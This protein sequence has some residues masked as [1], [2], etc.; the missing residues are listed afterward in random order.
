MTVLEGWDNFYV[1]VGSSAGA[2]IGLQFVV[3]T[4]IAGAPLP[5]GTA[6]GVAQGGA[7]F[8]TPSIVHYQIVLLLSAAISIPWEGI[9]PVAAILGATGLFGVGYTM[10]VAR[11]MKAQTLYQPVFEDWVY[12]A[13][14]PLAAYLAVATAGIVAHS[15]VRPALFLVAVA[16]LVLLF[17]GIHNAWDTVTYHLV[18]RR[19]E[20][21]E[22]ESSAKPKE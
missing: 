15:H 20:E 7:A 6:Q 8:S 11:R 4:L 3:I 5:R 12:H 17:V 19:A 14:L 16:T 22:N 18:T 10:N 13:W 9:T 21:S 2:L 1:I